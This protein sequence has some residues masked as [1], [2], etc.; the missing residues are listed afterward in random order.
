MSDAENEKTV[1]RKRGRNGNGSGATEDEPIKQDESSDEDVGPMPMPVDGPAGGP[2]KKRK[3]AYICLPFWCFDV[4]D[5]EQFYPMKRFTWTIFQT[6]TSIG[7][8]SCTEK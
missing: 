6:Q 7:K 5:Q 8:V 4:T 2:K 1:L 3:G